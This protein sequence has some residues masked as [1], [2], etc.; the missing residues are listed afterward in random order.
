MQLTSVFSLEPSVS[1]VAA[2]KMHCRLAPETQKKIYPKDP[3]VTA[4]FQLFNT[5]GTI[6]TGKS[7]SAFQKLWT[8]APKRVNAIFGAGFIL[9]NPGMM[10]SS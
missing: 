3:P 8:P 1:C 4:L 5:D 6:P 9:L 2:P 7:F 10:T